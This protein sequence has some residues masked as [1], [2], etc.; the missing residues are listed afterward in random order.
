MEFFLNGDMVL[1]AKLLLALIL[2]L[3]LGFERTIAGKM[4]GMRT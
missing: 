4:A 3:A 1:F 2:G